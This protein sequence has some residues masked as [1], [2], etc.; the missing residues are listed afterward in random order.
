MLFL[1]KLSLFLNCP[2]ASEQPDQNTYQFIWGLGHIL[3]YCYHCQ[4]V[5]N[6]PKSFQRY[7][8]LDMMK[9][10]R[11]KRFCN[12]MFF[13]FIYLN[14]FNKYVKHSDTIL[15]IIVLFKSMLL[16]SIYETACSSL[17]QLC[18]SSYSI[19]TLLVVNRSACI[20]YLFF[21]PDAARTQI[22]YRRK[23]IRRNC[24]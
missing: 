17:Q 5:R 20:N 1:T 13:L 23:R 11:E 15:H 6:V 19:V 2:N 9:I 14:S 12:N 4:L 18:T 21:R 24:L 22:L 16:P 8:A 10:C 7:F 3:G